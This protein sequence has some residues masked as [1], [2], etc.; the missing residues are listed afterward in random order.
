VLTTFLAVFLYSTNLQTAYSD[1]D[2]LR[3]LLHVLLVGPLL[4]LCCGAMVNQY[5]SRVVTDQ[6][7]GALLTLATAYLCYYLGDWLCPS[8]GGLTPL[9]ALTLTLQKPSPGSQP[10]SD[11]LHEL[12]SILLIAS[13]GLSL[14]PPATGLL[15]GSMLASV[16]FVAGLVVARG[17]AVVVAGRY[18]YCRRQGDVWVWGLET[19][20]DSVS[21]VF[22]GALGQGELW[23]LASVYVVANFVGQF[24]RNRHA[25]RSTGQLYREIILNRKLLIL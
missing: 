20:R 8:T 23:V 14:A 18:Y 16:G 25:S 19:G 11:F 24:F 21:F 5:L 10:A 4:G 3:M 12:L 2:R 22:A 1:M 17:L 9:L 13:T 6:A 15:V 7:S